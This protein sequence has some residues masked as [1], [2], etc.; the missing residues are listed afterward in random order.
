MRLIIAPSKVR[1]LKSNWFTAIALVA[2]ALNILRIVPILGAVPSGQ[3][4]ILRLLSGV[5]RGMSALTL[6]MGRRGFGYALTLTWIVTLGGAAGMYAFERHYP[7]TELTSYGTS[8]WWTAMVMTTL[9]SDYF[10]H[11]EAGRILGF[12]LAV[13]AFSIFGYITA[14]V[15]SFFIDRDASSPQASVAGEHS[16]EALRREISALRD[17][18]R[19]LAG[20]QA[21]PQPQ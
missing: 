11:T 3:V 13:F 2:P 7:G 20:V 6:V 9:G 4:Q 16:V 21:P 5:N 15:A 12:L 14:S 18:I 10:P 1:F 17:E 8:V 19:A